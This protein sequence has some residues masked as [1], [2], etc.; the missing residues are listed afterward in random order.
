MKLLLDFTPRKLNPMYK[1]FYEMKMIER[2]S[3]SR[4]IKF[5]KSLG[6]NKK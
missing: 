4:L 5:A 2:K 1:A 3:D 6:I